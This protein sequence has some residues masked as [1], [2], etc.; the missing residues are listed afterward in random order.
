MQIC[1]TFSLK[2]KPLAHNCLEE[3]NRN[4]HNNL[5]RL[6]RKTLY[7]VIIPLFMRNL[8]IQLQS[9]VKVWG[10][11]NRVIVIDYNDYMYSFPSNRQ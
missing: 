2:K 8:G 10:N 1:E 11:C 4:K 6:K 3:N 7:E 5:F 9:K